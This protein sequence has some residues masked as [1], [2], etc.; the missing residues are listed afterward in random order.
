MAVTRATTPAPYLWKPWRRPESH[1]A[2]TMTASIPH[3]TPVQHFTVMC[4]A[5]LCQWSFPPML[6]PLLPPP[7]PYPVM[8][9]GLQGAPTHVMPC[10][11]QPYCGNP[12]HTVT[13]GCLCPSTPALPSPPSFFFPGLVTGRDAR[14]HASCLAMAYLTVTV[15]FLRTRSR[16]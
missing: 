1:I 13:H 12:N 14:W 9:G 4:R 2:L 7:S 10:R 3:P 11:A 15:L 6:V 16:Y 5:S 8:L